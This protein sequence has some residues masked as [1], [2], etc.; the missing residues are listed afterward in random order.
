MGCNF[1][2]MFL[3]SVLLAA[4][5]GLA[6]YRGAYED[7]ARWHLSGSAGVNFGG[8]SFTTQSDGS[9]AAQ[10]GALE[11][12]GDI[13]LTGS[14]FLKDPRLLDF[15]GS[16]T[17][18]RS[19]SNQDQSLSATG[20]SGRGVSFVGNFLNGRNFPFTV[21]YLRSTLG[22]S[23]FGGNR[24][25][26]ISDL[27]FGW[28]LRS[29]H[30]PQLDVSYRTSDYNTSTPLA[31]VSN[32]SK[33]RTFLANAHGT[34]KEWNY[35]AGFN[36]SQLKANSLGTLVLDAPQQNGSTSVDGHLDRNFWDGKATISTTDFYST[37]RSSGVIGIGESKVTGT[38]TRFTYR[39]SPKWTA[40]SGYNYG[41][42][43]AQ[44]NLS[45]DN[46]IGAP[47]ALVQPEFSQHDA[48]GGAEFLPLRGLALS[49]A[50]HY[51]V[52][53]PQIAAT[54]YVSR[55]LTPTGSVS[56]G[57]R[58]HGLDLGATY[59]FS[60]SRTSTNLGRNPQGLGQNIMGNVGWGTVQRV[61]V[62][63]NFSY[64]NQTV[65]QIL[66]AFTRYRR[67][68]VQAETA[69]WAGWKFRTRADY[70]EGETLLTTGDITNRTE[71]VSFQAERRRFSVTAAQTFG[72]GYGAI[73]P[74]VV[75]PPGQFIY[76]LPVD[77]LVNTSLLDHTNKGTSVMGTLFLNRNLD[78][79]AGWSRY[80]DGFNTLS[81]HTNNLT[82]HALYRYGKFI[83]EGGYQ[84]YGSD[85][86]TLL[87]QQRNQAHAD[88]YYIRIARNFTFF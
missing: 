86:L 83:F 63:G 16:I 56:A 37:Q 81:Q 45:P 24:N 17:Q 38:D 44:T 32:N 60:V 50:V 21:S 40:H 66:G 41:R 5:P 8:G 52:L 25:D 12:G 15:T 20:T 23:G 46:P 28:K 85:Y 64:S 9:P 13:R 70:F 82:A 74:S 53:G 4:V 72:T 14:G 79:N 75:A 43:S 35:S 19:L 34:A 58:W 18:L 29:L 84:K 76:S 26:L 2:S 48:E 80:A 36:K 47:V 73:F 1:K 59:S 65:P 71:S 22:S 11:Y 55:M 30:F 10:T 68:M 67:A 31:F 57:R 62:S 3:V 49:G 69:A 54:E 87:R 27:G 7:A 33:T 78:L 39:F 51:T 77:L 88:R 61:R 6:Q 42:T